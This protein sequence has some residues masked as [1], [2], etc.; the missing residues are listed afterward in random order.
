MSGISEEFAYGNRSPE[1]RFFKRDSEY[2]R[3]VEL[4]SRIAQKL[5]DRLG[6]EDQ[7]LFVRYIDAQDEIDRLAAVHNLV[8]GCRLRLLMT[9]EAI[10]GMDE[11]YSGGEAL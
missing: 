6:A 11:L 7:D 10:M 1:I 9:A 4:L 8:H 2:G 3:A 5:P